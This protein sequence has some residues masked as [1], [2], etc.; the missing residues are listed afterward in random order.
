MFGYEIG[1]HKYE[2]NASTILGIPF[3]GICKTFLHKWLTASWIRKLTKSNLKCSFYFSLIFFFNLSNQWTRPECMFG[4]QPQFFLE[5]LHL[6]AAILRSGMVSPEKVELQWTHC[7][8]FIYSYLFLFVE[9]C[10]THIKPLAE[11]SLLLIIN[12]CMQCLID[13]SLNFGRKSNLY[14]RSLMQSG[15]NTQ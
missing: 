6:F 10:C 4:N 3:H 13:W 15:E 11:P 9:F 12:P 5:V 14:S 8:W 1:R 2:K 7:V